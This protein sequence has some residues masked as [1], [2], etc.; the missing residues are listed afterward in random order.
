MDEGARNLCGWLFWANAAT[1]R[2]SVS[3]WRNSTWIFGFEVQG[4]GRG[5][6][7]R[8]ER[9]Q[10]GSGCDPPKPLQGCTQLLLVWVQGRAPCLRW[11]A[12]PT[13]GCAVKPDRNT[14]T[15]P[16]TQTVQER[17]KLHRSIFRRLQ[18]S[19]QRDNFKRETCGEATFSRDWAIAACA[20]A[21][22]RATVASSWFRCSSSA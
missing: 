12:C 7:L 18:S 15:S 6:G 10:R 2:I 3:S 14:V 9:A 1:D 17:R 5:Q 22:W 21:A 8:V 20:T 19:M 16:T 11:P 4:L 13:R